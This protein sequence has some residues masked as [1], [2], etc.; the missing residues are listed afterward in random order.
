M[1]HA[2]PVVTNSERSVVYRWAYESSE[3]LAVVLI[4]ND[5]GVDNAVI[6]RLWCQPTPW[7]DTRLRSWWHVID[8][9]GGEGGGW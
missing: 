2:S 6:A 1:G 9:R 7:V 8:D 3:S 5:E 4:G